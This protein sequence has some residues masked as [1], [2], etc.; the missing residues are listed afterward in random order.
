MKD[1]DTEIACAIDISTIPEIE[2]KTR[3]LVLEDIVK[4]FRE[5]GLPLYDGLIIKEIPKR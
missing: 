3:Q 1:H 4:H 2:G 5:T